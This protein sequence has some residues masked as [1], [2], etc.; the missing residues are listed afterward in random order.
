LSARDLARFGLLFAR[1]G[2]GILDTTIANAPFL[3]ESLTRPAP[4]L[5]APK[6]WLR[7]SNH[8]MTD[9]RVIAHAGYGGQFLMVDI[10]TGTSCAFLSVLQN[11]AGYDDTYMGMVAGVMREVLGSVRSS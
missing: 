6:E 1:E 4:T 2:V 11:E 8:L 9:G 7:Y 5:A 10:L 3:N